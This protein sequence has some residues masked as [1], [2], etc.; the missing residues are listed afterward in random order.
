MGGRPSKPVAVI[1]AEGKS[2]R[3]KAELNARE[4]GEAAFAT[5]IPIKEK[6]ETKKNVVAH[7][8]F[9]RVTKLLNKIEKCDALYENII[10]ATASCMQNVVILKKSGRDSIETSGKWKRERR[11]AILRTAQAPITS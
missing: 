3:T 5:G 8:E 4:K 11:M 9:L 10:T 1:R 7:K 2:H 6:E